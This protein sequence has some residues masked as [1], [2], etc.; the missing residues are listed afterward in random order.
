VHLSGGA[1]WEKETH[2]S[3]NR[4]TVQVWMGDCPGPSHREDDPRTTDEREIDRQKE[5]FRIRV[6]HIGDAEAEA[7]VGMDYD[8]NMD[9]FLAG[10]NSVEVMHN[11]REKVHGDHSVEVLENCAQIV[12][13]DKVV[14][15]EGEFDETIFGECTEVVHEDKSVTLMGDLD[16]TILGSANMLIQGDSVTIVGKD[17]TVTVTGPVTISSAVVINLV[18][19]AVNIGGVLSVSSGVGGAGGVAQFTKPVHFTQTVKVTGHAT[20]EGG[21]TGDNY[22]THE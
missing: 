12:K 11:H 6:G 4:H 3:K 13:G 16:D 9:T 17:K 1:D 5:R 20:F 18:A 8:G 7:A 22:C 14:E 19:P 15:V 2:P 21:V 10:S